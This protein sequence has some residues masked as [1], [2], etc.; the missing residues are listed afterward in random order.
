MAGGQRRQMTMDSIKEREARSK[1][2]CADSV[3]WG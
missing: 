2:D 1:K 3:L